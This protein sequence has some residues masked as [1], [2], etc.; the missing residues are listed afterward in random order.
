MSSTYSD[1]FGDECFDEASL[2]QIDLL[3]ERVF[4]PGRSGSPPATAATLPV[5]PPPPSFGL[6]NDEQPLAGP[7]GLNLVAANGHSP[8]MDQRSSSTQSV[9][10]VR[11]SLPP[12]VT[13]DAPPTVGASSLSSPLAPRSPLRHL[14]IALEMEHR[15]DKSLK[16]EEGD[17][18]LLSSIGED[19]KEH[20][21]DVDGDT[22]GSDRDKSWM[23]ESIIEE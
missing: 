8:F 4:S 11:R 22:S 21:M 16:V 5:S 3:C 7:S 18:D 6:P 19:E 9:S 14:E 15:A 12:V 10:D 1:D 17:S 2:A 13:V 20:G 23:S